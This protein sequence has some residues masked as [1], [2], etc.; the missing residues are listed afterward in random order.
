VPGAA[1]LNSIGLLAHE[2]AP[3]NVVI[4]AAHIIAP[5]TYKFRQFDSTIW[6]KTFKELAAQG[7]RRETNY[8][9]SMLLALGFQNA[10]PDSLALVEECFERVHQV[11]WDDAMPE[12]DWFILDPI[13]P[14][15]WWHR[16]WDKC[17]RLRRGLIEA[18]V[19][20]RWPIVKLADCVKNDEFLSR[21]IESA[22]HVDGGK[23]LVSQKF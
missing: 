13:V 9:A 8:F 18:F 15:L 2:D 20:F 6:L 22:K 21:V 7:N 1:L 4:V 5:C 16:D 23:E 17:E 14:H 3:Q 11:A 19:K 12:D 10:P